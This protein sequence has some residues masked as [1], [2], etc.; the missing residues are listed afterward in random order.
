MTRRLRIE[1]DHGQKV[2][3]RLTMPASAKETGILLAHGAGAGQDHP[4][5]VAMRDLLA[6]ERFPTMTFNY[7]YIEAGRRAPDRAPKLLAVHRAAADRLAS[8][9]RWV[10]L[11]GKSMGGRVASH[12]VGDEGWPARALAYLGYPLV[13]VGKTVPRAIDHLH[14]IQVPHLFVSGTRDSLGPPHLISSLVA[15]LPGAS[16]LEITGG[17]HSLRVPKRASKSTDEVLGDVAVAV[18]QWLDALP[19]K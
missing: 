11:A 18:G 14:R 12:L 9:T 15:E 13:P 1:W 7:A 4:W 3:A 8:Y 6:N 16:H 19:S 2:T 17:D 10:V 5:M